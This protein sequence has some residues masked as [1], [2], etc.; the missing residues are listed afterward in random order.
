V[1]RA[2]A[3]AVIA[4]CVFEGPG[5]TGIIA[6]I[7]VFG[8]AEIESAQTHVVEARCRAGGLVCGVVKGNVIGRDGDRRLRLG[9][10][11]ADRAAGVVVVAGGV[12]KG[13]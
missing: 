7:G 9:Y 13:P 1:D 5:I 4:A 6:G 8:A 2:A 11:V 3:V 12:G 10:D